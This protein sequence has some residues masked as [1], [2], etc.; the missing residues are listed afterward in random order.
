[1]WITEGISVGLIFGASAGGIFALGPRGVRQGLAKDIQ[2][3][4]PLR[5][6][7]EGAWQGGLQGMIVGLIAGLI[8][9]MN[10][11]LTPL[12]LPLVDRG[13]SAVAVAVTM[14]V[15]GMLALGAIGLLFGGL[16]GTIARTQKMTANRGLR[17]A[18]INCVV[19]APLIGLGCSLG[20][21]L[22]GGALG[23]KNS[24]L[25]FGIYGW[26]IG[27]LAALWY[28]GLFLIQHTTLRFM[29]WLNGDT[30]LPGKLAH[31]LDYAAQHVF[32]QK[33]GSGYIFLHR[34][35]LEHFATMRDTARDQ[36]VGGL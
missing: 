36:R 18:L 7:R 8:A 35:L 13:M 12:V 6:S 3:V 5:W 29:L 28:G 22:L 34:Y 26:F 10:S 31:F 33:V 20:G 2:T 15:A 1:M 11:Q 24:A 16:R 17:L 21:L 23:G 14:A 27:L 30:P 4:G 25:V 19:I 9:G 32:L